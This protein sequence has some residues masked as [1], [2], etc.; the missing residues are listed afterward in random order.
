MV[1]N[2]GFKRAIVFS[3]MMS[4]AG[5]CLADLP[6]EIFST[7]W[8]EGCG[9]MTIA[10]GGGDELG[11]LGYTIWVTIWDINGD[12]VTTLAA[13]DLW[14]LNSDMA[15]CPG[16]FSQADRGTDETGTT[17]FSGTIYSGLFGDASGGIDCDASLLYVLALGIMLNDFQPVCVAVDSPDLNGDLSVS[18]VDFAKFASDFNCVSGCDPCH[19]FNE[20]G[21]TNLVDF[22]IFSGFF[23]N[24][25]CP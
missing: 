19:D 8:T 21:S 14:L 15:T 24:S 23:H 22:S 16:V 11:E 7:A 13:T 25:V 9:R 1:L 6:P 3:L 12:P 10:P 17:L 18:V 20:D 5:A 4:A 2:F